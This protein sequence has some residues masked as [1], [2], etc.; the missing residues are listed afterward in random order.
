MKR[1]TFEAGTGRHF[2]GGVNFLWYEDENVRIYAECAVPEG[3]SEDYGY[4]ALKAEVE[5]WVINNGIGSLPIPYQYDGQEAYLMGDAFADCE[6]YLDC[7]LFNDDYDDDDECR[8]YAY[9][10]LPNRQSF[11]IT[12]IPNG[13]LDNTHFYDVCIYGDKLTDVCDEEITKAQSEWNPKEAVTFDTLP[14]C[15]QYIADYIARA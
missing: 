12:R 9:G 1:I 14:E 2:K 8:Y 15:Y 3:A 7:T 4:V 13:D 6:V 11:L 5:D 10:N